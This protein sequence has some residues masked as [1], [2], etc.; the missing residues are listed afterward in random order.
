MNSLENLEDADEKIIGLFVKEIFMGQKF[1]FDLSSLLKSSEIKKFFLWMTANVNSR[2]I[3][4]NLLIEEVSNV[5]E[6]EKKSYSPTSLAQTE[7]ELEKCDK[8]NTLTIPRISLLPNM[9][10]LPQ[11]TNKN[12]KVERKGYTIRFFT[13]FVIYNA[14]FFQEKFN[15]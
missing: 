9:P 12:L 10:F 1:D 13:P 4:N 5:S 2:Q 14:F 6:S 11:Y 8:I 3:K 15:I 7:L